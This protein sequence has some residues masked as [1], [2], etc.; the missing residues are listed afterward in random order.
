MSDEVPEELRYTPDHEWVDDDSPARVGITLHAANELG[1]IVFVDLPSVGQ[2]V[3]VGEACG[4]IESTKSVAE[5]YSPVAGEVVAVNMAL[6]DEPG[7]INAEPY[8]SWLFRVE[9]SAEGPLLTA[10][11]YEAQL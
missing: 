2:Q 8:D 1:D 7:L 6:E 11:E 5:L 9:V 4:E 3:S 10:A